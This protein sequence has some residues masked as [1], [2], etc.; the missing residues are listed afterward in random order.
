MD[1]M[2]EMAHVELGK[3]DRLIPG[4]LTLWCEETQLQVNN[5]FA[6]SPRVSIYGWLT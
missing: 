5:L 2:D 4:H 3:Q 6:D 1:E